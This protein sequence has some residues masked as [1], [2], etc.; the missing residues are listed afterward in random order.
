MKLSELNPRWSGLPGPI[1]DGVTFDCPHCRIAG[2]SGDSCQRIGVTFTP[3]IDPD[4]WWSR[5]SQPTY[6]GRLLWHR[7]G[8]T[9]ETLTLTPSVNTRIDAKGHWHGFIKN[10][11]VT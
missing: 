10:G 9:F 3:P 5:I 7:E 8:D 4:G 2:L 11:E 1:Y 6:A